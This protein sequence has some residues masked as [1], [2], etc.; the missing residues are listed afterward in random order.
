MEL[1]VPPRNGDVVEEDL[2][3][4]VSSGRHQVQ[5]QKETIAGT[6]AT[7]DDQQRM[8]RGDRIDCCGIDRAEC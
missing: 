1:S 6:R 4:W 8:A 5:V 3:L 2:A 7:L